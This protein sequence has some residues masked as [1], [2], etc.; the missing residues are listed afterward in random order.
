MIFGER[1]VRACERPQTLD[2]VA[3][4]GEAFWRSAARQGLNRFTRDIR[5]IRIGHRQKHVDAGVERHGFADNMQP[6]RD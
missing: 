2:R 1:S 4:S 6:M 3:A 5:T